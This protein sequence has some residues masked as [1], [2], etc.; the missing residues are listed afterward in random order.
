MAGHVPHRR[1][2]LLD[3][4]LPAG[5]RLPGCRRAVAACH[6][7]PRPADALSARCRS[8]GAWPS[9][10]HTARA[11]SRCSRSC[12]RAGAARRFV[13]CLLGFAATDFVITITLS[14]ADATAHIVEQ[15]VRAGMRQPSRSLSRLLLL[16]MRSARLPEGI[17]RS[18]R[19]R[20]RHR[21]R[22]PGIERHR[23]WLGHPRHCAPSRVSS[24][25]A[26]RARAGSTATP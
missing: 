26:R 6:A 14:A 4:R 1:R 12:C 5:H 7:R 22:L 10:A 16:A 8:T 13:L 9:T 25:V 18:H 3:P 21:R 23:A 17:P 20:G 19:A 11:A 15:S 2:L 24:Q